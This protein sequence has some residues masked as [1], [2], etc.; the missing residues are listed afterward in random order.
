MA[1]AET[2][3]S[4]KTVPKGGRKGG[5]L[6]PK[7][8]L[9]E[10]LEYSAKLVSKTHTGAQPA[11]TILPGVFGSGSTPG[12]VRA[13]ALKQFGLLEG[14]PQAYQASKLAK[15]IAAAPP[16][17]KPAL[18]ERA[19]LS[20]KLFKDIFDTYSGDTVSIAKI[21]QQAQTLKVHP[22]S[23]DECVTIFV[24]S[25]LA[26]GLATADGDS[27]TLANKGAAPPADSE[28]PPASD[29]E[30]AA[31]VET[32]QEHVDETVQQGEDGADDKLNMTAH[33]KTAAGV[34]VNLNVDSSSDPDKLQK[35]LELLRKF[36]V[37]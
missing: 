10:A 2:S 8:G 11:K 20:S 15:D 17:E 1:E 25:A 28:T 37:I 22:D 7:T 31:D 12:Q 19:F 33:R 34:T 24:A 32:T 23:S 36:G 9:K 3:G 5:T 29:T 16:E 18:L 30:V 4:K 14:T 26:A 21:K 6:F 35:Q 13:S 27:V